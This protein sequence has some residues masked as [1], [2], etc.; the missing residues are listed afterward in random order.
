MNKLM[1]HLGLAVLLL[2]LGLSARAEGLL[3]ARTD[4]QF[5]EAMTLLQSAISARGYKITRLQEVNENLAKRDF[6]SDMYRVVYFGKLDE[7]KAV[8]AS[9]PEL[10]PFLPL[11]ITIFAEGDQAILVASHPKMLEQ[12]FP[13]P[14]LKPVF[15]HWEADI[16]SIL[17]ELREG[18]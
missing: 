7:V 6:K 13:D 18:K 10:I 5:P 9:H 4:N 15:D 17:N 2:S 16:L 8:T 11:N 14:S 1:R 12:F 3:M